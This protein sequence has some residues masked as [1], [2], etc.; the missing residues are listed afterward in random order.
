[1]DTPPK[2]AILELLRRYKSIAAADSVPRAGRLVPPP[3]EC[4][5]FVFAH[6]R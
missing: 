6:R 2:S 1:M 4:M 3:S 5:H